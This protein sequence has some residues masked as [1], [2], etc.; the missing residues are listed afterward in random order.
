MNE[1][2]TWTICHANAR[3]TGSALKLELHPANANAGG[4]ILAKIAKQK[5]VAAYNGGTPVFATFDWEHPIDA[6]LG[7]D[8]LAQVLMVLHGQTESIEDGKG[9]FHR[10]REA[11]M[12]IKFCHMIEPRPGYMLSVSKKPFD[13]ELVDA[14]IVLRVPE[15]IVLSCALEQSFGKLVFGE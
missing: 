3:G 7:V 9:V 4:Y 14:F 15:A 6:K 12:V 8:E 11:N 13:G 5:T 10:T 2:T 1:N